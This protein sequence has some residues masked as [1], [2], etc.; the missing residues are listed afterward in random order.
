MDIP[1]LFPVEYICLEN[2]ARTFIIPAR[3]NQFFQEFFSDAAVCL[4]TVPMITNST[5]TMSYTENSF[6]FQ[7]F[8]LGQLRVL[9]ASQPIGDFF[10]AV[11]YVADMLR[12]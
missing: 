12:Q 6:W 8:D 2:L 10:A 7:H 11:K 1:A 9:G 4:I 5:L 3:Q